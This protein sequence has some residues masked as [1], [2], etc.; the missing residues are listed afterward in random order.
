[1]NLAY[2]TAHFYVCN[3]NKQDESRYEL[4]PNIFDCIQDDLKLSGDVGNNAEYKG[5]SAGNVIKKVMED[6]DQKEMPAFCYQDYA[7][8]MSCIAGALRGNNRSLGLNSAVALRNPTDAKFDAIFII[9]G[10]GEDPDDA[11]DAHSF[12][13]E[14][15]KGEFFGLTSYFTIEAVKEDGDDTLVYIH[16]RKN[17]FATAEAA[18]KCAHITPNMRSNI[19]SSIT[20]F[21]FRTLDAA[22]SWTR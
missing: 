16:T 22:V 20:M 18:S 14:V 15:G 7:G 11:T 5:L 12:L 17:P 6:W 21:V 13:S 2:S 3:L 8:A 4:I 9:E 1:V 10:I 19:N